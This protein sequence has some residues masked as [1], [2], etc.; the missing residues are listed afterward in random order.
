M[1]SLVIIWEEESVQQIERCINSIKKQIYKSYEIIIIDNG[2]EERSKMISDVLKEAVTYLFPKGHLGLSKLIEYS[3]EYLNGSH[4]QFINPRDSLSVDWLLRLMEES[5]DDDIIIGSMVYEDEEGLL[6]YNYSI[7]KFLPESRIDNQ[8]IEEIFWGCAGED[9]SIVSISGKAYK[10]E[11][12][13]RVFVKYKNIPEGLYAL[14][15]L[16]YQCYLESS[17]I[18][19]VKKGSYICNKEYEKKYFERDAKEIIEEFIDSINTLDNLKQ[20]KNIYDEWKKDWY[21]AFYKKILDYHSE[22]EIEIKKILSKG[23]KEEVG[24]KSYTG[25][26]ENTITRLEYAYHYFNEIKEM[27]ASEK[28][29]YVGFDIFDT[30]IQRAFWEPID[31]FCLLNDKYNQL[32]NKKTCIDFSL[33]RRE[34]EAACRGYYINIRPMNEDVTLYQ[35]YDYISERYGIAKEITDELLKYE[36]QL[37][38]KYCSARAIGK[39]LFELANYCKKKIFIASDMYLPLEVIKD[40]LM[41]NGYTAYEELYLSNDIGLSKYSGTLFKYIIKKLEIRNANEVCFIGDNY[42]VDYLN[43][44]KVGMNA[45]HVPKATDLFQGLNGAL[46]SGKFFEKIY[47]PNGSIIDQGSAM[48]FI[49]IRCMMGMAANFM[50]GNPFVTINRESDFSGNPVILGYYCLGSFLYSEA[51]WLYHSSIEKGIDKIHFVA[52]DGYWIKK[53]YDTIHKVLYDGADSN[54]IYFSRKAVAPL[55]M[56]NPEGIY[57]LFLPPHI[58]NQ[59]PE[60]ALKLLKLVTNPKVDCR[61]E[62]IKEGLVPEKKFTTLHQFYTFCEVFKKK[63]Y[64]SDLAKRYSVMMQNYFKEIIG[65]KDAICDVG[66]SG[67]METALTKLLGYPVDSF[68]FHEHEPWAL[69]RKR[70]LG[71]C[72]NSFYSFK[73]CSAFVLREQL[74]TPNLPS[75]NGFEEINGKIQPVFSEYEPRFKESFILNIIQDNALKFVD[76]MVSVFDKDIMSLDFNFF[77]ACIPLEHYL[78][79]STDFDRRLFEAIEFEDEFGTNKVLSL[80]EYWT[81]ECEIYGLFKQHPV[82]NTQIP[83]HP[84]LVAQHL[85]RVNND[86]SIYENGILV[87]TFNKLNKFLPVGGKRRNFVKKVAGLFIK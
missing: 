6:E 18:K 55:Y 86:S 75:C 14:S 74:L 25:F 3:L 54:Y 17:K 50:F 13:K 76:D 66:Y 80:K 9:A 62:L 35:I 56:I 12:M 63:L 61:K 37:E 84:I 2:I 87:K 82:S 23:L 26:F 58:M 44:Q 34:G 32:I 40:I 47:Q 69:M 36:I 27:I 43:S 48:K 31:L 49:G 15:V 10:V 67:R 42:G 81:K 30:L 85:E 57:E 22:E 77:D 38:K 1:V 5:C 16:I 28:C 79:F 4:V 29:S 70:N 46:Y 53:A 19:N 60:S 45:F 51:M 68:Y 7:N 52:R 8:K 24:I 65:E 71:F 21:N 72:I 39:E 73:P 78:H 64:D 33:I 11:V 20:D 83:E 59:T 41:I